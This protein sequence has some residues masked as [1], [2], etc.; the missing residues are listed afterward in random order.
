MMIAGGAED[1]GTRREEAAGQ[2]AWWHG[3]KIYLVKNMNSIIFKLH[4]I[5]TFRAPHLYDRPGK[6]LI[7]FIYTE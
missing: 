4:T 5:Y 7:N 3:W 1:T 2:V 6:Q